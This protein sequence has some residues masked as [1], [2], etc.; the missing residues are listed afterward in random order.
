MAAQPYSLESLREAE[1]TFK[2]CEQGRVALPEVKQRTPHAMHPTSNTVSIHG[3]ASTNPEHFPS[4]RVFTGIK[5]ARPTAT[6][7]LFPSIRRACIT[8]DNKVYL[9]S[10]L[11][12]QAAFEFYCIPDDQ[13]VIAA[14]VVPVRAGVFADIVT[15]V[16]V[17]CVGASVRE[18]KYVKILG[19]SYTAEWR[20]IQGRGAGSRHDC[21]HQRVVL[22]KIT[23]TDGGRIFA[24]G[25]DNC[26][27][28]L[29]YQRNEGWFTNKCY[30]RNITNPRLSN[31]L[32]PLSRPKRSS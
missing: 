32:P 12:G 18:G 3:S 20:S 16:L 8:V 21:Q 6:Q 15:H 23:G 4:T 9:W 26:L 25:S 19:L 27:Y 31:L 22:D 5:S 7:S 28:E 13:V 10:Y 24:S 17:L 29:V 30:L 1:A 2:R 14:S 11:E